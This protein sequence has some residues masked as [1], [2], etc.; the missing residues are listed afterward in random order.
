MMPARRKKN[1]DVAA[2]PEEPIQPEEQ[3]PATAGAATT[4]DASAAA[5]PA[6]S[7][8]AGGP[9]EAPAEA[10]SFA[11]LGLS[12]ALLQ[13]VQEQSFEEPTPIQRRTIPLL[14]DGRDVIA[15]AQTGTGKTAAFALP[16][17]QQLD[18][19]DRSVQSLVLAPT[20]ELAVQVAGSV[21]ALGRRLGVLVLPVYGGQPIERQLRAL[22][23]GVQV[24]IG[25]PGRVLDHLRRG[26]LRLEQVRLLV[27]DEADE[28]LD[29]GFEE[30]IEAIL[31]ELPEARQTALF[32]ATIPTRIVTLARRYLKDPARVTI[33]AERLTVPQ[34]QQTYYA[35]APRA[36]L[37]ALTRILDMEGPES[38]IIF[39]RTKR[40]VD[41][42]GEALIS[43]G[44]P[45]ETLHGDL[46]QPMRDRVMHRFREG[47]AEILVATDVAARGLDI[48]H[49]SH[50]VNFDIPE[51]PEQYIHRIG[52]TARA[53]RG[54][55]AITLVAPREMRLLHEIERLIRKKIQPARVP[56]TGDI[57]ARR[58][59]LT[60]EAISRAIGE[61]GLEPY[62]LAIED[63][64]SDRDLAEVAAAALRL[65]FERD[66]SGPRATVSA[67]DGEA[68][69]GV[70]AGMQRLFINL[71]RKQGIRPGDIVGAITNEAG[72]PG[73]DIGAIDLYDNFAFVEVAQAI[74]KR[75]IEALEGATLHG[76]AFTV[77]IAR[78]REELPSEAEEQVPV[79][80]ARSGNNARTDNARRPGAA[81]T[82]PRHDEAG[83]D[84]EIDE[85]EEEGDED[86]PPRRP[87]GWRDDLPPRGAT[88]R[89]G[90]RPQQAG[91][92]QRRGGPPQ[93]NRE[94]FGPFRG[95]EPREAPPW[96][97]R[98][99]Q[100]DRS[101]LPFRG[102]DFERGDAAFRPRR[103]DG[104]PGG[105]PGR[106][107][108]DRP[109]HA[110]RGPQQS[111]FHPRDAGPRRQQ[112][113]RDFPGGENGGRRSSNPPERGER[114]RDEE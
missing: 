17:L 44:Y 5:S 103:P 81:Q 93:R 112:R 7:S 33:E 12:P 80:D 105:A 84:P 28:M 58:L 87:P 40:G 113:R 100:G 82:G 24:V 79:R 90:P 88:T 50:V 102:G 94:G 86:E 45:A 63:L 46:S 20:R 92:Q 21:H 3:A 78:P 13:S 96:Q 54:G 111:G 109:F 25:T 23:S 72:V 95:P 4:T 32:S 29:M 85:G 62:L 26:S 16:L 35:V 114:R 47:Q 97:R 98:R 66:G 99:A 57:A 39:C 64:A 27:L 6:G 9:S 31:S 52:R 83:W 61:G 73:S 14:L 104:Q 19:T 51:D 107:E 91:G 2:Q 18:L 71:G 59:E 68:A 41:E 67:L 22:R 8:I 15:Q 75:T 1:E 34:V 76:K 110:Q 65:V 43:R 38:A 60:K 74:A 53:G 56:S 101:G 49:I 70:E 69:L 48:E 42:I 77:D 89:Y 106:R 36:K 10:D 55:D 11:G 30:E 37:D 108:G